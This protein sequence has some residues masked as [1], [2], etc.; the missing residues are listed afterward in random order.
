M[1]AITTNSSI[2]VKPRDRVRTVMTASPDEIKKNEGIG[3]PIGRGT[4]GSNIEVS[5]RAE[6]NAAQTSLTVRAPDANCKAKP[7]AAGDLSL[8]A[9]LR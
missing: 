6:K 7:Q 8:D 3:A 5:A 1:M 4:S 2:N 9:G